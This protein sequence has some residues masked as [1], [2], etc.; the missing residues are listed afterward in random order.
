[1]NNLEECQAVECC[2]CGNA[3]VTQSSD[4]FCSICKEQQDRSEQLTSSEME[5][6][7]IRED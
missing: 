3:F 1:M 5:F 7:N 6:I 2:H 4:L